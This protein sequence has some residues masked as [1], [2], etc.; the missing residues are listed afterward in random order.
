M[1]ASPDT[2]RPGE[3]MRCEDCER[4]DDIIFDETRIWFFVSMGESL[5]KL[6]GLC[7]RQEIPID[8]LNDQSISIRMTGQ[9]CHSFAVALFGSM[10]HQELKSIRIL[11]TDGREP[12]ALDLGRVVNG[13]VFVNRIKGKWIIDRV[14]DGK[15]ETWYQPIYAV[16]NT[17]TPY[18][19]EA[20]LRMRDQ[21]DAIIPPGYVFQVA[22][23]A[24]ALFS[25]DL[26]ARA[27]A[28]ETAAHAGYRGKIFVNFNPS[29]I[30]D[31]AY[32]LRTTA[33]V[34]ERLGLKPSNIVFEIT[35]TE[36]II[37]I[38]HLKG[39]LAF[40]RR[41][42]YLCALDDIGSGYSGLNLLHTFRPDFVKLDMDL[43]R[44]IDKDPFKQSI[45]NNL[46]NIA[47]DQKIEVIAEGIETREEAAFVRESGTDY[48]QGFLFAKPAPVKEHSLKAAL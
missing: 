42:G 29:S 36:R 41:A 13:D 4:M 7:E 14:H 27:S 47:K 26:I 37:D 25:V 39:I 28:I 1:A 2:P 48:V 18:G 34:I 16:D 8:R 45:V 17:Q 33:A 5:N 3:T 22:K 43:I 21:E 32:C 20:L 10:P 12:S 31:P 44:D 40:Y 35:E 19:M 24:D 38:D 23:D 46:I 15:V 6:T 9:N 30:Y 11:T